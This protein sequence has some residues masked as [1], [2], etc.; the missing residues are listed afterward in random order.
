LQHYASFVDYG[1]IADRMGGTH[2]AQN[3]TG[4][5]FQAQR[6]ESNFKAGKRRCFDRAAQARPL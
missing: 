3:E 5:L 2:G 4:T 1:M 6:L